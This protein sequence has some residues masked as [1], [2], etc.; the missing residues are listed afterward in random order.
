MSEFSHI[1]Y[2]WFGLSQRLTSYITYFGDIYSGYLWEFQHIKDRFYIVEGDKSREV[3]ELDLS[4]QKQEKLMTLGREIKDYRIIKESPIPNID[5]QQ[6]GEKVIHSSLPR[7]GQKWKRMFIFGAGASAYCTFG[8]KLNKLRESK[9]RPPTGYEIF[10]E[11][12]DALCKKYPA[13][14]LTIPDFEAKGSDIEKCLEDEWQYIRDSYNPNI[15]VRHINIQY[16]LFE[17]FQEISKEVFEN[18]KRGNLYSLF[19][20]KLQKFLA[21]DRK[22]NED[23]AIVSFNYDIILDNFIEQFFDTKFKSVEHYIDYKRNKLLFLKPHGSANWGW[24]FNNPIV[25]TSNDL[26][27][28]YLYDN[29]FDLATIYYKLLG[30]LDNMV[31][32]NS[33]GGEKGLHKNRLG[34]YTINKNRIE[35]IKENNSYYPALL[36]PYRDKDEFLMPYD[37]QSA[38]QTFMNSMEEVYLIGWKGNEDVFNRQLEIH[39]HNL[40]RI[41]IVNPDENKEQVVSKNITPYLKHIKGK[42]EIT[43]IKDFEEF[44]L[45]YMDTF[46]NDEE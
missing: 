4:E 42:Y 35:V 17:L 31:V 14:E 24:Q 3:R 33:L 7:S 8:D 29:K 44:V 13:V 25:K 46:L 18:H 41:I 20:N 19:A 2:E 1:P 16:Y 39:A 30:D 5:G 40:K 15:I 45:N 11:R 23:I 21:P 28:Q 36:L 34:R 32:S 9:L 6:L 37:H 10:D 43:V 38:L 26:L 27:P 12:Y 22:H